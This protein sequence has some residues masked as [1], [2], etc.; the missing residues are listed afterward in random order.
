MWSQPATTILT[1]KIIYTKEFY[2]KAWK[3]EGFLFAVTFIWGG[4][5]VFT[6]IGLD[7]A[8]PAFY[9]ILRFTLA[10]TLSVLVFNK[11]LL[12]INRRTLKNGL[13]L[14]ALFGGGFLL[15]TYGLGLTSVSKSAF[16]TGITVPITPLAYFL[17]LRKPIGR[18]AMIGVIVATIGLWVFTNPDF[19]NL[20]I[21]DVLTLFSTIFWALYITLIDKFTKNSTDSSESAQLVFLQFVAAT[22]LAVIAFFVFD[23]STFFVVFNT[24]LLISLAFNGIMASFFVTL[25]HTSIQ[26]Y[27]TPVKAALIFSLEPIVASA[28]AF[29]VFSEV[30]AERELVGA[31]ILLSAVLISEVGSFFENRSKN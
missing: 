31:F 18:A 7:F 28:V 11:K 17:I 27:T 12:N 15:Q 1:I 29:F 26:R 24:K 25:I 3:A 5:F 9:I 6:K 8:Q 20:N 19:D 13:A 4:T 23:Y 16:I 14:G 22:P 21:G 2:V 10:L 30:L